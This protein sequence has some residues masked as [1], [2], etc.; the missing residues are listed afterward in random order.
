MSAQE[1]SSGVKNFGVSDCAPGPSDGPPGPSDGPPDLSDGEDVPDCSYGEGA[2]SEQQEEELF[3]LVGDPLYA[4]YELCRK[5]A[6]NAKIAK[7][8][9]MVTNLTRDLARLKKMHRQD[10]EELRK[11]HQEELKILSN[12]SEAA[13]FQAKL[14]EL[15]DEFD[16]HKEQGRN[17]L[18]KQVAM[19]NE[20]LSNLTSELANARDQ[21]SAMG[22]RLESWIRSGDEYK[23]LNQTLEAALLAERAE[24]QVELNR[25]RT[26]LSTQRATLQTELITQHTTLQTEL[27]KTQ[28]EL[29]R[30]LQRI[31]DGVSPELTAVK[32]SF[33]RSESENVKLKERI[34]ALE[35]ELVT[36]KAAS[37][38]SAKP[39]KQ[40]TTPPAK[41]APDLS[42]AE[43]ANEIEYLKTTSAEISQFI[44]EQREELANVQ[45][46]VKVVQDILKRYKAREAEFESQRVKLET[47]KRQFELTRRQVISKK[48]G[49][50]EQGFADG[51]KKE[52][53][54]YNEL[55]KREGACKALQL[56]LSKKV[57]QV[58]ENV[59]A[60][61]TNAYR[62]GY[63]EGRDA[64][65]EDMRDVVD[66]LTSERAE[67]VS[68][69]S[70]LKKSKLVDPQGSDERLLDLLKTIKF[71]S[72]ASGFMDTFVF[73]RL[74]SESTSLLSE[75]TSLRTEI[76]SLRTE[77][78]SLSTE[79]TSLRTEN[80]SLRTEKVD[81]K[82]SFETQRQ[83]LFIAM[84]MQTRSKKLVEGFC[85]FMLSRIKRAINPEQK[86]LQIFGKL[87]VYLRN[88]S[89]I[90]GFIQT[91]VAN[92]LFVV[93]VDEII[94]PL[95]REIDN[96]VDS[97]Q[98]DEDNINW[99]LTSIL[100]CVRVPAGVDQ[101]EAALCMLRKAIMDNPVSTFSG[102][103]TTHSRLV[104]TTAYFVHVG[105]NG[106]R[107]LT[108]I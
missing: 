23:S 107:P 10:L 104:D 34:Q 100:S 53:C 4:I 78:T 40:T 62:K 66:R 68:E 97:K 91:V 16:S 27:T 108:S 98:S 50:Y 65:Q 57:D 25:L 84:Q 33:E 94:K 99:I 56:E 12:E 35:A 51:V 49:P 14:A 58:Q 60:V 83:D 11:E 1:S 103:E 87:C 92:V 73:D 71:A 75:N 3:T 80:T 82:D 89:D 52:R 79:N 24:H 43:L 101:H 86:S 93:L 59:D 81:L 48:F 7:L 102:E 70:K 42:A 77:I 39:K 19:Y 2:S 88:L 96:T 54:K 5:H 45:K 105:M 28:Q 90:N 15:Q 76:T 47:E 29:A 18:K 31:E 95:E 17:N 38:Q 30:C 64:G 13:R 63:M 22:R 44:V 55:T 41:S 9:A 106:V 69:L 61:A 74:M 67:I 21:N 72:S 6:Q 26:E 20:N 37:R 8:Q 85:R 36:A 46:E 32:A